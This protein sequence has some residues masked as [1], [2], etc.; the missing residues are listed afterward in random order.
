MITQTQSFDL[1][2]CLKKVNFSALLQPLLSDPLPP[3]ATRKPV[4]ARKMKRPLSPRDAP[5]KGQRHVTLTH[6][7]EWATMAIDI[8]PKIANISRN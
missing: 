2:D 7:E 8:D 4:Y 5:S 1:I 3:D 6:I